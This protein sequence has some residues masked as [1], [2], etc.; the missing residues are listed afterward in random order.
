MIMII[1]VP[2]KYQEIT[3]N[4]VVEPTN[5]SSSIQLN[6]CKSSV[7]SKRM[8][9]KSV[10]VEDAIV[11][12]GATEG[13]FSEVGG[14]KIERDPRFP[15]RVTLQFYKCTDNGA[16]NDEVMSV[17]AKQISDS[18]KNADFIGS[19]VIGPN[20]GR[21][22]EHNVHKLPWTQSN[23]AD[24]ITIPDWW[25]NFWLTYRNLFPQHNESHAKQLVFSGGRFAN[26]AL[27]EVQ[28]RVLEILGG[29][30]AVATSKPK[31]DWM[32]L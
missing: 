20:V 3:R 23:N 13:T 25:N 30:S 22:T 12:V 27:F 32:V 2:L 6:C 19:L 1:Q 15:V 8:R 7:V 31:V 11:K 10:N 24:I 17:I 18:R 4:C 26:S 9:S 21:P 28:D 14:L 29:H 16:V 5:C